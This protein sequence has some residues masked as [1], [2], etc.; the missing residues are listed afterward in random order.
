MAPPPPM[1]VPSK[2]AI[3]ALRGLVLG[4]TCSLALVTED[5][6]RRINAAR[7]AIRNGDRIRSARQ[8]YPGGSAFAIALE[9]ES[10][11]VEPG[12]IHWQSPS[13]QGQGSNRGR[14]RVDEPSISTTA[15]TTD[16]L[17]DAMLVPASIRRPSSQTRRSSGIAGGQVVSTKSTTPTTANSSTNPSPTLE[18]QAHSSTTSAPPP[19]PRLFAYPAMTSRLRESPLSLEQQSQEYTVM[20]GL[21]RINRRDVL[22]VERP[23][24]LPIADVPTAAAEVKDLSKTMSEAELRAGLRRLV[25]TWPT[26]D[27]SSDQHIALGKASAELCRSCQ[28][29][30]HMDLAQEVLQLAVK[31][32]QLDE[33]TYFAH[34]PLPVV[35]SLAPL[36]MLN[37]ETANAT[38]NAAVD[39]TDAIDKSRDTFVKRLQ[40]AVGIFLP[41]SS[42]LSYAE[43]ELSIKLV[44]AAKKLLNCAFAVCDRDM[45]NDIYSSVSRCAGDISEFSTWYSSKIQE[46]GD[47]ALFVSS[48]VAQPPHADTFSKQSFSAMADRIV[49]ATRLSHYVQAEPVFETL[50]ALSASTSNRLRTSW[51][52]DLLYGQWQATKDYAKVQSLF[53]K[54]K[55]GSGGIQGG[56]GAVTYHV[57]GAYRVMIQVALEAGQ[58]TEAKA[59]LSELT[60]LKRSAAND[61]RVLGLFALDKAKSGDWQGVQDDFQQAVM[62]AG[63]KGLN[64]R[65]AERVFVPIAKEYVRTHTIG[66]TEDFLKLYVEEVGIPLGKYMVTLLANEYGA[67]REVRSFVAWLEYCTQAGFALDAAFSNAILQSCRKHWK[68]GFRDL[69]AMYRKLRLL[70]PNFEDSVTQTIMTHAA[71]SNAKSIAR[72]ESAKNRVLSLRI[73]TPAT[74]TGTGTA[75]ASTLPTAIVAKTGKV[76]MSPL[77]SNRHFL[78]ENDLYVSMKQAFASGMP[79]KVVRMYKHAM[80]G[81]MPPSTKCLKLAVGAAVKS[82]QTSTTQS[83]G[84]A[85]ESTFDPGMAIELLETAHTAGHDIDGAASYLVI[86]YIDAVSPRSIHGKK[87]KSSKKARVAAAVKGILLRLS[88]CGVG[89]SDLALNRAAFHMF[90]A[91]H[92]SGAIALALSAADLPVGGGRPGYNVWNYSVLINAYARNANAAGIRMATE[93]AAANGVLRELT[94]YKVLKQAR[95]NLRHSHLDIE[96]VMQE[97]ASS[98][99]EFSS[100]HQ[101]A[102]AA[103]QM[104]AQNVEEALLAIEDALE[105]ARVARQQLNADRRELEH[106]TMRIMQQAAQEA[107]NEPVD[108]DKM[109]YMRSQQQASRIKDSSSVSSGSNWDLLDMPIDEEGRLVDAEVPIPRLAAAG[110]Y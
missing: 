110:A 103:Q 55:S 97:S 102:T 63:T 94:G 65:D 104:H 99:G 82:G 29:A 20:A 33:A 84:H 107:G 57:D 85:N 76:S 72:P 35:L 49:E 74:G 48:F 60:T 81:G 16:R 31:F 98:S 53:D 23:Q 36:N 67:L 92:M 64:A 46:T 66:E 9:E 93:G 2:A 22:P 61:I 24:T 105:Q 69:R 32:G 78:N 79:A 12:A 4:T 1:P 71:V 6:R 73:N 83:D 41:T 56:V 59:L 68:F 7:S 101:S 42:S 50:L 47:P 8:Y 17:S 15:S 13:K 44:Q 27:A 70:S 75:A 88:T 108:V 91:G 37:A 18:S 77:S 14:F 89:I 26:L 30:G 96:C 52:T 90:K 3:R 39:E 5:R 43:T 40:D 95:R 34:Q 11:S 54:L 106:A 28:E 80:R 21:G 100:H 87:R 10:L 86:A 51:V 19:L 62:A 25:T 58:C 45:I 38:F 109:Q